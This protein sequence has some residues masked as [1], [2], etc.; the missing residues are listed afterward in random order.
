[1]D[2]RVI[3]PEGRGYLFFD[4]H[5]AG[6]SAV[7]NEL[8]DEAANGTGLKRGQVPSG[9]GPVAVI[10]GASA[11]YGLAATICG[12]IRHG[13]RGAGVCVERSATAARTATAGWYR[14]ARTAQ[15]ADTLKRDFTLINA[16]CFHDRTKEY[17]VRLLGERYGRVD[18]LIYAVAAPRRADP[19]TGFVYRSVIKP[20]GSAYLAKSLLF[21]MDGRATLADG[22][23]DPASDQE[24]DE[25]VAVMGGE[26]WSA[27][28]RAL[29]RAGL[30]SPRFRTVAF[31]YTGPEMMAPIYRSGTIGAA[32]EHLEHSARI[33]TEETLGGPEA[34]AFTSVNGVAVTQ[35]LVAIP[36]M[37]L[38]A[39]LL[40]R[41]LGDQLQS[42]L[43]Q[44][45]RLWDLMAA[46]GPLDLDQEGRLRLD[47]WEL[48][49]RVQ[50]EV[51]RYHALLD[52]RPLADCA[53][54]DWVFTELSKVYGFG[55]S[56][57][58]YSAPT[59]VDVLWPTR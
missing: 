4:A 33:L 27:W 41:V 52:A 49:A 2:E 26:D 16:D 6:C 30:T 32:K 9:Q 5:P 47:D 21:E 24:R 35:A 19:H 44:M 55:V 53:D 22:S 34:V 37:P 40:R 42:P 54:T 8:I 29:T 50:R 23:I 1:M 36:G 45:I 15:L 17:L 10:I 7:V 38:Y 20:L 14:A 59:C 13:I 11:G 31:S 12:L 28:V 57:V 58:D 46:P 39:A 48:S 25:T 56:G 51:S 43:R 18:Y 3:R